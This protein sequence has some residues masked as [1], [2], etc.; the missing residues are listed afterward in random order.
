MEIFLGLYLA[1]S[2]LSAGI[3]SGQAFVLSGKDPWYVELGYMIGFG[4]I[5]WLG[6]GGSLGILLARL[7]KS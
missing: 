6:V 5:S 2:L 3:Y 4:I 1:G 7:D